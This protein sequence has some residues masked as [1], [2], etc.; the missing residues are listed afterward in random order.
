MTLCSPASNVTLYCAEA[1]SNATVWLF[2]SIS[3]TTLPVALLDICTLIVELLPAIS[4][5]TPAVIVVFN[6]EALNVFEA[7]PAL[8]VSLPAN[9]AVTTYSPARITSTLSV[10]TPFTVNINLSDATSFTLPVNVTSPPI[11]KSL[12]S[13]VTFDSYLSNTSIVIVSFEG[14][15]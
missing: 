14:S 15:K 9:V 11:V 2:P 4:A 8:C 13:I 10:T 6:L 12:S 3:I 7:F 5:V 1:L